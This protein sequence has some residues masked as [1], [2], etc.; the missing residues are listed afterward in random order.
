MVG[1]KDM[2]IKM[3]GVLIIVIAL[4]S[5][6]PVLADNNVYFTTLTGQVSMMGTSPLL[7]TILVTDQDKIFTLSGDLAREINKLQK[8]KVL[9]T[10]K[11]TNS[12]FPNTSG[13][14]EVLDYSLI[15]S[16]NER[17][18]QWALGTI[19]SAGNSYVLIDEQQNIY[20]I[21]NF[22]ELDLG[23]FD[24]AKLLL[25]GEIETYGDHYSKIRVEGYKVIKHE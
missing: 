4:F 8:G 6:F 13:N 15:S 12:F 3:V 25:F 1:V 10:G 24:Y 16:G 22:K 18:E 2:K 19:Y 20:E 21:T 7:K 11:V 5:Q 17:E 23:K 9:V 14:I